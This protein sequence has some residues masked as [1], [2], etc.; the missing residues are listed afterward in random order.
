LSMGAGGAWLSMGATRSMTRARGW[1]I[2]LSPGGSGMDH[3]PYPQLR[4]PDRV[5]G[6]LGL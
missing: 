3:P 1:S 4:E 2:L 6:R 5:P